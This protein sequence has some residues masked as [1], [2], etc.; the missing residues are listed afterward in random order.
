M[1]SALEVDVEAQV[2]ARTRDDALPDIAAAARR[3]AE[4]IA[5][6]MPEPE[7][8]RLAGR[9]VS[10]LTG[11]G[12]LESLA[13]DPTVTEIMVNGG[14][15]VWFERQ[16]SLQRAPFELTPAETFHIIERVVAP[17]GR[18]VDRTSPIVD[19]RLGDG[20]R[21]H[22]VVPPLAPDGPHL[23]IRR[24]A[25]Q[26]IPLHAFTGAEVQ[27][28]LRSAVAERRNIVVTGSTSSGKTSLLAALCA[29][30]PPSERIVTIEDAAELRLPGDHVVRLEARPAT[31]EGVGEVTIRDL[32][33][34]ALRMRPDRLVVGEVRGGEALDMLQALNTGH[35]GSLSTCHANSPADAL[36]RLEAMV[37]QAAPGVP[38]AAV[39]QQVVG[40]ID[41]VVHLERGVDGA[42]RIAS[43]AEV[44][45]SPRRPLVTL[46]EC[47]RVVTGF[48]TP[49]RSPGGRA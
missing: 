11:L 5:P 24:F 46:A 9:V 21:V 22:A 48:T 20:S 13:R 18:R 34:A 29:L 14:R 3:H 38:L 44:S 4:S 41:V 28:L 40:A 15:D 35:D 6:L 17:L 10:R 7:L 30:T 49:A 43:V 42:R 39:R 47:D 31:A 25:P 33:R 23:T 1:T 37:L 26:L 8:Q 16:G 19:A 12:P 36:Q 27:A 32:V 45:G 2:F